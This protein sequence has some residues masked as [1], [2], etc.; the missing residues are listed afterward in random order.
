MKKIGILLIL[1]IL[2]GFVMPVGTWYGPPTNLGPGTDNTHCL[3][4]EDFDKDGYID[5]AVGNFGGQNVVYFGDGDGTFDSRQVNIGGGTDL[6]RAI[7]ACDVNDDTWVDIIVGNGSGTQN[8]IYVNDGDGTFDI[9]SYSFGTGTDWTYALAA[10]NING[11]TFTDLAVGNIGQQNYVYLSDGVDNPYDTPANEIPF[12]LPGPQYG[13]TWDLVLADMND[14]T[15][16]DLVEANHQTKNHVYLGNGTGS[17]GAAYGLGQHDFGL[18]I[19]FTHSLAVIDLNGDTILDVVEGNDQGQ[20]RARLGIG[21]GAMGTSYAFGPVD[22][23]T[24]AVALADVNGDTH[25]DVA[26]ANGRSNPEQNKIYLGNGDGTF[27]DSWNVGSGDASW[28]IKF[29]HFNSDAL[30]DIVVA[31]EGQNY[32]YLNMET[33]INNIATLFDTYT[34][35]VAGDNAYCTDVLGSAKIAFGLAR[36]GTSG[37][38]EGRTDLI[39]TTTEHD[40]GNLIPVGGPGINPIADEFDGYFGITWNYDPGAIPP[41]FQI[42]AEGYTLTLNLND[43]PGEDICIVYIAEHNNRNVMLVWGYGWRGTYA[44]SAYIG[45]PSKW[46]LHTGAHMLMIRWIDGNGDGLVQM[47]EIAVE[48]SV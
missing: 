40:T 39:L 31:N 8:Y 13:N 15:F 48:Q 36:G 33:T 11:D 21:T 26:V 4:L 28:D 34:F 18:S 35:F 32:V 45:D 43:Y 5:I 37:N 14:D 42:F 9:T 29:E 22:D 17:F 3:A 19:E 41:V 30:I 20:N 23:R 12:G 7:L 47:G 44:G 6:T 2:L 46:A 25:L 16:L 24:Q 27:G 10:A 38:P 1:L